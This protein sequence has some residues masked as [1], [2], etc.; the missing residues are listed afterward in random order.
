MGP[1]L[2]ERIFKLTPNG[3]LTAHT[4]W[5][6]GVRL[7]HFSTVCAV[8]RDS[9]GWWL[10]S[11]RSSVTEHW[12]HKPGV[13]GLIPG[14]CRPFHFPLFLPQEHLISLYSNVRQEF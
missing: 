4:E 5:L 1:F 13:M 10:S 2:M 8:Y 6:P 3:V 14:G 11:C 9:E 12:L 7:R